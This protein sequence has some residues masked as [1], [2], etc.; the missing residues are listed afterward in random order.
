[1]I[2]PTDEEIVKKNSIDAVIYEGGDGA[3][4]EV[5]GK[6]FAYGSTAET[7]WR[8][9]RLRIELASARPRQEGE[10]W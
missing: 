5:N 9:A 4:I 1:M 3:H 8:N 2:R 7:A 10:K 6:W